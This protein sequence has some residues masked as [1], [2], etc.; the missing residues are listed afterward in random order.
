MTHPPIDEQTTFGY[1]IEIQRFLDPAWD[2]AG[3]W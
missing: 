2:G 3:A 1:L